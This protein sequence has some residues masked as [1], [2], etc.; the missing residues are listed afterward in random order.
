MGRTG[1]ELDVGSAGELYQALPYELRDM[2]RVSQHAS[3]HRVGVGLFEE[4]VV[5][6]ARGAMDRWE[7]SVTVRV[8]LPPFA[9]VCLDNDCCDEG[10]APT[11]GLFKRG[12]FFCERGRSRAAPSSYSN[13]L[14]FSGRGRVLSFAP[15]LSPSIPRLA[16]PTACS[17]AGRLMKMRKMGWSM[18]V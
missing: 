2:R 1:V 8:S 13:P 9:S 6:H 16:K 3:T 15:L 14:P 18:V 10:D 11:V 4:G 7:A 12:S 17:T 5:M